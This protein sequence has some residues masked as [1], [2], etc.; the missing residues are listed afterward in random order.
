MSSSSATQPRRS[1]ASRPNANPD[2]VATDLSNRIAT[3]ARS[4]PDLFAYVRRA[5]LEGDETG[6]LLFDGLV[7][8]ARAQIEFL[9]GAG[10]LHEDLDLDWAALHEVLLNVGVML[11]E[12]LVNR[13]LE[14]PILS[15]EGLL[16]FRDAMTNLHVRGIFRAPATD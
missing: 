5:L 12:G 9:H 8:V 16:R 13:H 4:N 6:R 1:P 3:F 10:A 14:D 7:G 2:Q 15:D 11:L